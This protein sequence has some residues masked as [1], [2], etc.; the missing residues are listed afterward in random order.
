MLSPTGI[1][2][3]GLSAEDQ[4]RLV[5]FYSGTVGLRIIESAN[6]YTLFDAGNGAMFEIWG[7]GVAADG[8]KTARQQSVIVGFRV[9]N[10]ELAMAELSS[11]ELLPDGEIGSHMGT[12]WIHYKDPEGNRF[13]LK[14]SNG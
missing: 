12:R 5:D 4:N 13:E 8:R 3:V 7:D 9:A 14:D 6:G 10:L 1:A 2:W 11:R